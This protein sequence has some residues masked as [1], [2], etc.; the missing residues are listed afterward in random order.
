MYETHVLEPERK[1]LNLDASEMWFRV[2]ANAQRKKAY[3]VTF[4]LGTQAIQFEV[5][6]QMTVG[7]TKDLPSGTR[8]EYKEVVMWMM[9]ARKIKA[10]ATAS[11]NPLLIW[12][13]DDAKVTR[14]TS[15]FRDS[16]AEAR[17]F[18]NQLQT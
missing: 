7:I 6:P 18:V 10:D 17:R 14:A 15:S 4:V 13:R 9:D 11:T 1:F 16:D 2:G 8:T 5:S 3:F 12:D